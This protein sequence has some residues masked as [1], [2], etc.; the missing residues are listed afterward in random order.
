MRLQISLRFGGVAFLH[1]RDTQRA[2]GKRVAVFQGLLQRG[3]AAV[4]AVAACQK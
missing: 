1:I 4:Y 3:D 2:I